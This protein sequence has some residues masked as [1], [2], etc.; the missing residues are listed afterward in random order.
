MLFQRLFWRT[1]NSFVTGLHCCLTI[2]LLANSNTSCSS[3]KLAATLSFLLLPVT[4]SHRQDFTLPLLLPQDVPEVIHIT[5][6]L[7]ILHKGG[8]FTWG[9][10]CS[11]PSST[12]CKLTRITTITQLFN[13]D[14]EQCRPYYRVLT[15]PEHFAGLLHSAT[16]KPTPASTLTDSLGSCRGRKPQCLYQRQGNQLPWLPIIH[17]EDHSSAEEAEV[18]L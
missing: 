8:L 1:G 12:I 17:Q 9:I 2:P 4:A 14:D 5:Q 10:C 11:F 3:A 6:P 15:Q 7:H 16:F 13:A 18:A